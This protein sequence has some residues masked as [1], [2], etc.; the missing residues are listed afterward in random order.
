MRSSVVQSY[1]PPKQAWASEQVNLLLQGIIRLQRS[2]RRKSSGIGLSPNYRRH[3][4]EVSVKSHPVMYS[5][6][7]SSTQ[8][9]TMER[10]APLITDLHLMKRHGG[11]WKREIWNHTQVFYYCFLTFFVHHYFEEM[12]TTWWKASILREGKSLQ[13]SYQNL[14]IK[15][16]KKQTIEWRIIYRPI[17]S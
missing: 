1:N 15:R 4:P 8:H 10:C 14:A 12:C 2:A 17:Y 3:F 11:N 16:R 13:I 9:L 6:L 5:K 7:K